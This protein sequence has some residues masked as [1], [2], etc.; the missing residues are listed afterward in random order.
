MTAEQAGFDAFYFDGASSARRPVRVVREGGLLRISGEGVDTVVALG[1]VQ[2]EP[3]V[4][5]TRHLLRLPADAQ[6]QTEDAA[7]VRRIFP[8]VEGGDWARRLE[9]R[10]SW[11][12][13]ALA[14]IA[15]TAAWAVVYGLPLGA[16]IA[17][18][19]LPDAAGREL[20]EQ[21]MQA[22]D[23]TFCSPSLV[24]ER[25][26]AEERAELARIATGLAQAQAVR[27]EFR[28]CGA[29]GA[30]ALAL[31]DG[32]VMV[33]DELVRLADKR[34]QLAA[35]LAHEVGHVAN[36]HPMRMAL[37]AAGLAALITTLAA[38]AVAITGL[39]VAL[40][41]LLLETGYS[42]GFEE[43]AD[44]F[45]LARMAALGIA[46]ANFADILERLEQSHGARER[47]GKERAKGTQPG[48]YLSTHPSTSRRVERARAAK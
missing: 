21:T 10:W 47:A 42:R 40:P 15:V 36:R 11:A 18:E 39:A 34:E 14:F 31:P 30:N 22:L 2:V 8:R 29:I 27:L 33:T 46:P 5:G 1:D 48:D 17:A 25:R 38:D 26:Q 45:A 9:G 28:T 41:T 13:G 37:Q 7:A 19:A 20:G 6:L 3:P 12:L 24:D 4:G 23:A 35:V 43:E 16:R 44:D 32:T